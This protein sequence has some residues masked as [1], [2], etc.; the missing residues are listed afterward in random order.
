MDEVA[1]GAV[2]LVA[3]FIVA[4]I[5]SV[6]VMLADLLIRRARRR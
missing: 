3:I 6:L 4:V 5:L 2:L 1:T